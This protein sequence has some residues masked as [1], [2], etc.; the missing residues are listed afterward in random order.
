[1]HKK[2]D[3]K[4][5]EKKWQKKWEEKKAFVVN[6]KSS[7]KKYN[8]LL[9]YSAVKVSKKSN[10]IITTIK[11][12]NGKKKNIIS[13]K[14][15]LATGR[16]P[17]SDILDVGKTKVKTNKQGYIKT[18]RYM[19]TSAKGIW[20]LGDIA[21]KFFFKHSANLEANYCFNNAFM[22]KKKKVD[23]YAMPHAIFSSPQ[24]AGVGMTE[25]ELKEK[26]IDYVV[27]KK[28][29]IHTGMGLALDDQEGFVKI[30]VDNKT[31]KILGCHIMGTDAATL[32]H[33]VIVAMKAKQTVDILKKAV[34]IHPALSEVVQ[35]AVNF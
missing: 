17:N 21:G 25:Q 28:D 35:R 4:A 30:L 26:K 3:N 19:E 15:L 8:V 24:I 27:G 32:I 22:K 11:N 12:K 33:E 16:I 10:K 7:K 6:E 1:M 29:Y 2:F 18:N 20:V 5:I 31:R 13:E 34:H 9:N 14:L 23:Y